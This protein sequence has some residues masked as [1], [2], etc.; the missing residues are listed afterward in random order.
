MIRRALAL[1]AIAIA[2]MFAACQALPGPDL[3]GLDGTSWRAVAV[4]GE[5]TVAGAEPTIRFEGERLSGSTGCNS[6]GAGFGDVDGRVQISELIMT[7][8]ACEGPVGEQERRFLEALM[9]TER[10]ETGIG[11]LRF[12]GTSGSLDFVPG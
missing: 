4:A 6:F 7:E 2:V 10:V 11:L 5:P 9:G 3:A 12:A 1:G 8:M